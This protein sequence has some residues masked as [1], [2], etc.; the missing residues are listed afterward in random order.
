MADQPSRRHVSLA[1]SD[2]E[3]TTS[4]LLA[5]RRLARLQLEAMSTRAA[6]CRTRRLAHLRAR[7]QRIDDVLIARGASTR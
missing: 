4:W 3:A 1:S 7:I 2:V 5:Q 6:R